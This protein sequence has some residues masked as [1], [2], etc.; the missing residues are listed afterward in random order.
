[1]ALNTVP[2]SPTPQ[3]VLITPRPRAGA[4]YGT[5]T[6][7]QIPVASASPQPNIPCHAYKTN[8][9]M[10]RLPAPGMLLY[11]EGPT[12]GRTDKE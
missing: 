7:N 3:D 5:Q 10:E 9:Q 6:I 2:S 12:S 8:F 4:A 1:M 11:S